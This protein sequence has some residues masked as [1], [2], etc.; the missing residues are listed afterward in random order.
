MASTL[1]YI[2]T[3]VGAVLLS[4]AIVPLVRDYAQRRRIHDNPGGHKSHS[5]PVPYLGGVAMVVAFSIAMF[6]G[7]F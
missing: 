7:V 6:L 3:F 4:L 2:A 5:T 1:L